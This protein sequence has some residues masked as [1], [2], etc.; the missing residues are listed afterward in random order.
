MVTGFDLIHNNRPLQKHWIR[1]II[2]FLIDL[3]LSSMAAYV[4]IWLLGIRFMPSLL[5]NFPVF[6]GLIQVFYSAICEYN[7]RQTFGKM[8]LD[9]K[10]E[11]LRGGLSLHETIIRNFSKIHGLL[12]LL[13]VIVGMATRG[14]PRQ[15]YLDRVADT[16][17]TST[18]EPRH[19]DEYLREHLRIHRRSH[20][21][22]SHEP[23][24]G[25]EPPIQKDSCEICGGGLE[26]AGGALMRCMDCGRIQ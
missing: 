22:P 24:Q 14:D 2:A 23:H 20:T 15:R 18:P 9:L 16:T 25:N 5:I 12:V 4:I 8:L 1:R 3:F 10:V 6:A 11:G 21:P 26:H 17:V 7:N 13:D 19:I